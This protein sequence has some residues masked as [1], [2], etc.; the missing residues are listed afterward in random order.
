[1]SLSESELKR[2]QRPL[3]IDDWD[4]N[5]LKNA[6]VLIVG[7]GGLGGVTAT[8]LTAAGIGHLKLCDCDF[9]ELSNLNRQI[10]F[11]TNDI[12]KSKAEVA[13]KKLSALNP[14]INIDC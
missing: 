11:S 5:K 7:L 3:L 13:Q 1:M 2:Y 14:D 4:Q 8:Y 12:G 9:V 6:S 10:L